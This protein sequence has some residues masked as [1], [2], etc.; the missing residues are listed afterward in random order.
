M[1]IKIITNFDYPP[2]PIRTMDWSAHLDGY[3]PG[4]PVGNGA[5]ED[6]AIADL[7]EQL[8]DISAEDGDI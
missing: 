5:T 7:V 3:E 2:I 1:A 4:D 8:A 6:E